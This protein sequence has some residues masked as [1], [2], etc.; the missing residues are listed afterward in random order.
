M[1]NAKT[2]MVALIAVFAFSAIAAS[3]ASAALPEFTVA[4]Y[5]VAKGTTGAYPTKAACEKSEKAG[6]E[7]QE[8]KQNKF[9]STSG[10]GTLETASA[11][12][13][14][15]ESDTN[16]GAIT[17]PKAGNVKVIFKGC[18]LSGTFPCKSPTAMNAGEILTSQLTMSL[19]FINDSTTPKEAGIALKSA[20][21][22]ENIANIECEIVIEKGE[23]PTIE[24][25]E[26]KGSVIGKITP[27]SEETQ[28]PSE[29]T[30]TL[31]FKQSGGK[32]EVEKLEGKPKDTLESSL[33]KGIFEGAGEQTTDTLTTTEATKV[34]V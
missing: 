27:N 9:T 5:K 8:W 28:S 22:G 7:P 17:G 30:F 32:Q 16:S 29:K 26:V 1:R 2:L 18:K 15:C 11:K 13:V 12:K 23:K 3:V 24:T 14:T 4:C 10:A 21:T 33:N 6:E 34:L 19:G 20:V 25:V 31:Q